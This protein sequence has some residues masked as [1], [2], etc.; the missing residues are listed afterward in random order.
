MSISH[1]ELPIRVNY[2]FFVLPRRSL[3]ALARFRGKAPQGPG[4]TLNEF[5]GSCS[6][7]PFLRNDPSFPAGGG[8]HGFKD[9]GQVEFLQ[10]LRSAVCPPEAQ[11]S[12]VLRVWKSSSCCSKL[13]ETNCTLLVTGRSS[14][15]PK[16]G[17]AVVE[18]LGSLPR[19][20]RPHQF[21]KVQGP[22]HKYT[23]T[24]VHKPQAR[25]H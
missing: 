6:H 13:E 17:P 8:G 16:A 10:C 20:Q 14:W 5:R 19:R 18:D 15:L 7:R 11:D 2:S 22:T 23:S 3:N 1:G 25:S 9:Q 4:L 21:A 12:H 24:Q